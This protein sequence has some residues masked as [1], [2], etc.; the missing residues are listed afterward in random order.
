[1]TPA[2]GKAGSGQGG[3]A[4][5]YVLIL[6]GLLA[7]LAVRI[8]SSAEA[9]VFG[10][11]AALSRVQARLM[12]ES[13]VLSAAK[14]IMR[15]AA[16]TTSDYPGESWDIFPAGENVPGGWFFGDKLKGR[17]VDETGKLPINS[18]HP[19]MKGHQTYREAFLRL[20]RGRPFLVDSARAEAIASALESWM[21]SPAKTADLVQADE[22][23]LNAGLPYRVKGGALDT[24]AELRLVQ[25]VS[26]ELYF[27]RPGEVGLKDLVTIWS[28]GLVNVNTAPLPVL[29]AMAVG[30]DQ[31][32]SEDFAR[33]VDTFRRTPSN[34]PR[35]EGTD[36]L[37]TLAQ[38]Q[39]KEAL[40]LGMFTT[41]SLYFSADLE[42]SSGSVTARAHAVFKRQLN[43]NKLQPIAVL[44]LQVQ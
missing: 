18:I 8:I 11:Q 1:M 41:R 13:A 26:D 43:M 40:P 5:I 4:L 10:A 22:P 12:A 31:A 15:D 9:E 25:G 33:S 34:R 28:S 21:T 2:T 6:T 23:Y 7:S 29:A 44:Y 27:G 36:W 17:I 35:L 39:G 42:C 30:L 19:D 3:A 24:V 16:L 37:A 32:K 20:L 38:E 14:V